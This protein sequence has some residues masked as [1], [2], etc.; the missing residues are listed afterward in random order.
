MVNVH[1]RERERESR[2]VYSPQFRYPAICKQPWTSLAASCFQLINKCIL[3]LN[4]IE[5]ATAA[6]PAQSRLALARLKSTE[7]K[8][9]CYKFAQFDALVN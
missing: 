6:A 7:E 5:I 2:F 3:S 9:F 4:E 8:H 1:K